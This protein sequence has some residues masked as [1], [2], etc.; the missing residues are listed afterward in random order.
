[1][2][3]PIHEPKVVVSKNGPYLVTGGIP[4]TRQ[5]IV[6]VPD[7]ELGEV[8]MQCVVPRFSETEVAVR[9]AGPSLG[10]HNDEVFAALGLSEQDVARLKAA[11]TI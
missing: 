1:M 8:R 7:E 4:L 11:K 3:K 2:S 6:S 10:Q 5:T 9:R